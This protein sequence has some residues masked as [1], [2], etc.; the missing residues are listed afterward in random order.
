MLYISVH[1]LS[2]TAQEKCKIR[3]TFSQFLYGCIRKYEKKYTLQYVIT[4]LQKSLDKASGMCYY[5]INKNDAGTRSYFNTF[6]HDKRQGGHTM[7]NLKLKRILA[8]AAAVVSACTLITAQT[9]AAFAAEEEELSL[10]EMIL[11][12][13]LELE[14]YLAE[15]GEEEDQP[16]QYNIEELDP[17]FA[18]I[19]TIFGDVN[20]DKL[21]GISDAVQ[22][23]RYL[24]GQTDEL[25]NWFNA[26]LNQDGVINVHDFTL[27]KQQICGTAPQKGSSASINLV[28][29][30]TDEPIA[31]GYMTLFCI[32]DNEWAYEVRRWKNKADEVAFFSGLPNDPKYV[33]Y[34][35]VDNLPIG[36]NYGNEIGNC[37]QQFNFSFAEGETNK[38]INVRL[39]SHEAEQNPNVVITQM[40]WAMEQNIL[41]FGYNYGWV[42]IQ[43]REGNTFYQRVDGKGCALPDGEYT[44]VLHPYSDIW[45][46]RVMIPLDPDSDFAAHIRTLHPD[47]V[48][49]DKSAGIDFTVQNGVADKEIVFDFAPRSGLSNAIKVNCI[50]GMTG[51]P[52]EGVEITLIEAPDTEARVVG[53]WVSDATGTHTFENLLRTGYIEGSRAYKLCVTG[54]PTGFKGGF[55]QYC[56]SSMLTDYTQEVTYDFYEIDA[57]K[58]I[59]ASIIKYE[60]GSVMNGDAVFEVYRLDS[61]NVGQMTKIYNSVS[62][63]EEFA[64]GDGSYAACLR[65]IPEAGYKGID[66]FDGSGI[67]AQFNENEFYGNTTF[68]RFTVTDGA[69]DRAL[70]F[71]VVA[72]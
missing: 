35:D 50:N 45:E 18:K 44:A 52:L 9:S 58:Q 10:E 62:V 46:D 47:V 19:V 30:M 72:E 66:L 36:S 15:H 69:P 53:T 61:D 25:G 16:P 28:D 6:T 13:R 40:D 32:Y 59:S 12:K 33:Y 34:I 48:L 29:V 39:A 51:A 38:A 64:L 21:I 2:V 43:D 17:E 68:I 37:S 57:P 22:L 56:C 11:Q 41:D 70:K 65:S 3:Y 71:Y 60:D 49:T 14:A 7:T 26:D 24:L 63:G 8:L 5:L 31:G 55:D 23:Q 67:A 54:L 20:F 27:L 4:I 42:S 1:K